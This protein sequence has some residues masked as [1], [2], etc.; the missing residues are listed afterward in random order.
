MSTAFETWR[1]YDPARQGMVRAALG[2]I[3]AVPN[4]SRD[5]AEMTARMLG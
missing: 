5:L 1:R 4:L 3:A 2:R